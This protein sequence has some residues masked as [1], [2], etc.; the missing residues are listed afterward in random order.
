MTMRRCL[1]LALALGL[2]SGTA[3][4]AC[5]VQLAALSFGV[6]DIARTNRSTGKITIRC[7]AEQSIQVGLSGGGGGGERRLAGPGKDVIPYFVYTGPDATMPWGD[8]MDIGP[9]VAVTLDG[10]R[11]SELPVYGVIPPVPGTSPGTYVD[12]L[13]VT[14]IF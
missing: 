9:P 5:D 3:E 1:G 2:A 10:V 12:S 4:A 6:I 13:L 7:D 8:G 14:I 11:P